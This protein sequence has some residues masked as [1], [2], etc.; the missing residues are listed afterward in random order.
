[1][2]KLVVVGLATAAAFLL[3]PLFFPSMHRLAFD[4]SHGITWSMVIAAAVLIA[5]TTKLA[6][7]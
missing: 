3:L 2:I 6:T 5:G 1:M 4:N 7:K